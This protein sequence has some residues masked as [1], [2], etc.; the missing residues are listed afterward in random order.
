MMAE[1]LKE[2]GYRVAPVN[3]VPDGSDVVENALRAALAAGARL[4][5]T[6][7]GTG[8]SPQDLTPEGTVR[9]IERQLPGIVERVRSA[10]GEEVATAVLSRAV[11][12]VTGR[13][14]IVNAPGSFDGASTTVKVV[15]SLAAHVL[16]QLDGGD[17][18]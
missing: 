5:L 13:A 11:A 17:H 18:A 1:T 3:V 14:L 10:G 15:L 16:D 7:G 8:I 9:V 6:T 12:G 4:I 2:A